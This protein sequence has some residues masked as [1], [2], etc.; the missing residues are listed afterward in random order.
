MGAQCSNNCE[1]TAQKIAAALE[2]PDEF[3]EAL[4]HHEEVISEHRKAKQVSVRGQEAAQEL[5]PEERAR[6]PARQAGT[7][8]R[9]GRPE[10]AEA[11]HG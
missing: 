2:L 9:G 11:T 3:T 5:S 1:S 8:P 7:E 6:A 4:A 10:G